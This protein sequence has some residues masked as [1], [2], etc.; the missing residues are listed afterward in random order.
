MHRE[1]NEPLVA[2]GEFVAEFVSTTRRENVP[3]YPV[4]GAEGRD[5][6]IEVATGPFETRQ[7]LRTV[8][9][10]LQDDLERPVLPS[11]AGTDDDSFSIALPNAAFL[12]GLVGFFQRALDAHAVILH[13]L[14]SNGNF[15]P[16]WNQ[17]VIAASSKN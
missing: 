17:A 10:E 15:L 6:F 8:Y 14:N 11:L 4:L 12:I 5:F 16:K 2:L 9:V 13:P 7:I 1:Q 3:H